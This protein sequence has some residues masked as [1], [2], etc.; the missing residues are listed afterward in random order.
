MKK[1]D[2]YMYFHCDEWNSIESMNPC[3]DNTIY[4][5]RAGRRALWRAIMEDIAD[6][7]IEEISKK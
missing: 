5:G 7:I 1:S 6:D 3:M 2:V 4:C